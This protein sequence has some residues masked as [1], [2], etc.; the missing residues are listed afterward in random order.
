ML[1]SFHGFNRCNE[2][3]SSADQSPF[4]CSRGPFNSCSSYYCICSGCECAV[5]SDSLVYYFQFI[6]PFSE[7]STLNDSNFF[8]NFF[9]WEVM[10]SDSLWKGNEAEAFLYADLCFCNVA[11][12]GI[13]QPS[14]YGPAQPSNG[15]PFEHLNACYVVKCQSSVQKGLSSSPSCPKRWFVCRLRG[16]WRRSLF[17]ESCFFTG[18]SLQVFPP[19]AGTESLVCFVSPL[20]PL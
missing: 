4:S 17:S 6:F 16:P 5:C 13:T 18:S 2:V 3:K 11:W 14:L 1:L 7:M 12:R 19:R 15:V 9:T 8:S 20:A 10:D